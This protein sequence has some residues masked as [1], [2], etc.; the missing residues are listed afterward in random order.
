MVKKTPKKK[1]KI[2]KGDLVITPVL[3]DD[4]NSSIDMPGIILDI[5]NWQIPGGSL[6]IDL[7]IQWSNGEAYWC[8]SNTVTLIKKI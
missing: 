1:M 6:M 8:P 4:E 2:K 3:P 7:Y 5:K